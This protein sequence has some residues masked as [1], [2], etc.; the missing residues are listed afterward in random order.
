MYSLQALTRTRKR[1][2]TKYAVVFS[3]CWLAMLSG[4][5][6][7][8]NLYSKQ[9]LAHFPF[10][11]VQVLICLYRRSLTSCWDHIVTRVFRFKRN[12]P[13]CLFVHSNRAEHG[14]TSIPIARRNRARVLVPGSATPPRVRHEVLR[15]CAVPHRDSHPLVSVHEFAHRVGDY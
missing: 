11:L 2:I 5:I 13:R 15:R 4:R 3:P 7:C 6:S 10:F 12:A 9:L 14:Q 8:Q 1:V